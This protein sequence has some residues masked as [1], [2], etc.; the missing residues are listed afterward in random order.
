MVRQPDSAT[1]GEESKQ[2]PAFVHHRIT[3]IQ[4]TLPTAEWRYCP[5]LEN[6]ADLLTRGVTAD[7]LLSSSLWQNG[8]TWLTTPDRWPSFDQL[9]LPPLLVA[10]AVATEF[11]PADPATPT[12][13][14]HCVI[15]LNRY[16][17]L[18][19]LLRVT[20]YVF[21]FIDNVRV[22]PDHRRYEPVRARVHHHET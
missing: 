6:P 21:R 14:L 16:S 7:T 17:T 20:A 10:A 2:L 1:L 9:P 3:D 15:L 4:S 18:C 12:V 11:V 22:Q 5:N 8:P 19:K 13:G